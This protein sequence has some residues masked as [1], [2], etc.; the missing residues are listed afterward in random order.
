MA[1]LTLGG[2]SAGGYAA[3]AGAVLSFGLAAGMVVQGYRTG[4][5]LLINLGLLYFTAL[6]VT[7]YIDLLWGM[8]PNSL[9]FIGGGAALLAGGIMLERQRRRL[10]LAVKEAPS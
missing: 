3:F 5:A 1:L 2:E 7:R 4:R 8:L 6:V 9:V 10:L